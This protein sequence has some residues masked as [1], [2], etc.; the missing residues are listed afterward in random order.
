MH[1]LSG[2]SEPRRN[3]ELK[4]RDPD[5][6][7]SLDVCDSLGAVEAGVLVQTDTYFNVPRGRLKLREEDGDSTQLI[8]YVRP[9]DLGERLSQYRIVEIEDAEGLKAAL[10]ERL[11]TR[12]VVSKRRRLFLWREVRIHLDRVDGLGAYLEFEAVAPEHSDLADERQKVR[13]LRE[14]FAIG[15]EDLIDRSYSDLLL[16]GK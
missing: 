15:A 9:D 1:T 11:G 8:S 4:A 16:E 14:A 3:I 12:V 13:H 6:A 5:P 7:R 2:I 10:S